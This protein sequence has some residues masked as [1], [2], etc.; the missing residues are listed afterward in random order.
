MYEAALLVLLV[1]GAR[2]PNDGRG[3]QEEAQAPPHPQ[4]PAGGRQEQG[5]HTR[6]HPPSTPT[7]GQRTPLLRSPIADSGKKIFKQKMY[8]NK[9]YLYLHPKLARF[10]LTVFCLPVSKSKFHWVINF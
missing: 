5:G 3:A 4:E 9:F 1:P 6:H 7:S 2:L 8:K 10:L